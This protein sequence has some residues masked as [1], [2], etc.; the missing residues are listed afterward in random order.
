VEEQEEGGFVA[1]SREFVGAIGQGE[2][3][4]DAIADIEEAIRL[5]KEVIDED[6]K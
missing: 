1:F 6:K 5:L 2:T 3:I 4:E